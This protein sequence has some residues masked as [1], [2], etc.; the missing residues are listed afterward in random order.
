MVCFVEAEMNI[1]KRATVIVEM[2]NVR[3]LFQPNLSP[4]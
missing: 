4:T 2:I 3:D 1:R